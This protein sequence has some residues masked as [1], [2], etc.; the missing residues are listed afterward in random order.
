[1]QH[2][3]YQLC[4]RSDHQHTVFCFTSKSTACESHPPTVSSHAHLI[5]S[6]ADSLCCSVLLL[7]VARSMREERKEGRERRTAWR[8]ESDASC[9]MGRGKRTG[10]IRACEEP[11]NSTY[12]VNP[13]TGQQAAEEERCPSMA[14]TNP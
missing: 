2:G 7:A 5:T 14:K 13:N 8:S 1:M 9:I 12:I 11:S 6:L 3:S 4:R 10:R